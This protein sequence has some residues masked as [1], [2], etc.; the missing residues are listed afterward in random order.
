MARIKDYDLIKKIGE[1]GMGAVYLAEHISTGKKFAVKTILGEIA[2]DNNRWLVDRFEHKFRSQARLDHPNIVTTTDF[3]KEKDSLYMV[4]EY[5]DG[6]TLDRLI[7]EQGALEENLAL[8][9]TKDI[10]RGLNYAHGQGV[11]H[12]N[13]K[14]SNI[15]VSK[16]GIVKVMDFGS[17]VLFRE[18]SKVTIEE[19]LWTRLFPPHYMT[20][21]QITRPRE[22]DHRTNVYSM[23]IVMYEM[24]SGQVP[25][26][27]DSEFGIYTQHVQEPT[28]DIRK[29]RP[30]ISATL[31][32]II[33]KALEKRP[34]DRFVSCGEMLEY[35]E[36]YE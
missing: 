22:I 6:L 16:T 9:I 10:L 4:M 19:P 12:W 30:E 35:I 3:I 5:I 21:E 23:G 26:N 32:G 8:G 24:L 34:D 31:W 25:F 27:A 13:M 33:N 28:P 17:A 1:D 11:I 36:A 2:S 7:M 18:L 20:P 29:F 15:I 14:P